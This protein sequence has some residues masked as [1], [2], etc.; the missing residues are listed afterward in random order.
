MLPATVYWESA[1]TLELRDP[2]PSVVERQPCPQ[3]DSTPEE[4]LDSL[5]QRPGDRPVCLPAGRLLVPSPEGLGASVR[6][7]RA[8]TPARLPGSTPVPLFLRMGVPPLRPPCHHEPLAAPFRPAAP[9]SSRPAPD[10]PAAGGGRIRPLRAQPLPDR[11]E[12]SI[13]GLRVPGLR[14]RGVLGP[15]H[16][17]ADRG[18]APAPAGTR[19]DGRLCSDHLVHVPVRDPSRDRAPA[20]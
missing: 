1:S 7:R 10:P 14:H 19:P 13:P 4:I 12:G 15:L 18:P 8:R 17:A 11:G 16:S 3:H 6:G 2:R 5:V 20:L 9:Q